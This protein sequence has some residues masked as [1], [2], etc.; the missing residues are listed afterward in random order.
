MHDKSPNGNR[1]VPPFKFER[2]QF[3]RHVLTADWS[4]DK[5]V[6]NNLCIEI[7][8]TDHVYYSSSLADAIARLGYYQDT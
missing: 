7:A 3:A 6:R 5:A 4:E 2:R 1:R 8:D